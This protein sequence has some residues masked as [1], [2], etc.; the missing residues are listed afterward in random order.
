[1]EKIGD[2]RD[3]GEVARRNLRHHVVHRLWTTSASPIATGVDQHAY[4]FI[5]GVLEAGV[6]HRDCVLYDLAEYVF[7]GRQKLGVLVGVGGCG[8]KR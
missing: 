6:D 3:A 2:G 4:L 8:I 1:M 7:G 5:V